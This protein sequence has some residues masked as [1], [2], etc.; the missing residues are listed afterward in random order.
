MV[1]AKVIACSL[2]V[3]YFLIT[4]SSTVVMCM[5]RDSTGFMKCSVVVC[6][7]A[8]RALLRCSPLNPVQFLVLEKAIHVR[9]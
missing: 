8:K 6:K 2:E 1:L 7:S 9:S 4:Y 5:T 3:F